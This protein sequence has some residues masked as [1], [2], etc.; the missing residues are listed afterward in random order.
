MVD[1]LIVSLAEDYQ[2]AYRRY[3]ETSVQT[4]TARNALFAA[5]DMRKNGRGT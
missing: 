3:G 2:A 1:A 5:L 4:I